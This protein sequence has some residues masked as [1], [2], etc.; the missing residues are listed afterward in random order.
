MCRHLRVIALIAISTS[1]SPLTVSWAQPAAGLTAPTQNPT[2]RLVEDPRTQRLLRVTARLDVRGRILAPVGTDRVVPLPLTA[3]ANLG[4]E[5]R[6]LRPAGEFHGSLRAARYLL[7]AVSSVRVDRQTTENNLRMTR[8][9]IS[10]QGTPSGIRHVALDGPLSGSE[11]ELLDLPADPLALL[12]AMPP[13][14]VPHDHSWKP[15][16][17]TLPL[18]TGLDAVTRGTLQGQVVQVAT[19][20]ATI[21]L[22]GTAEGAAGGAKSKVS[23]DAT[24]EFDH[25]QGFL[26]TAKVRLE[27]RRQAGPVSPG[28]DIVA[29]VTINRT[30]ATSSPRLTFKT[31]SRSEP[32]PTASDLS[33]E[34]AAPAGHRLLHDRQWHLFHQAPGTTILRRLE[35]GT[36]VSQCNL[37]EAP[38]LAPGRITPRETFLADVKRALGPRLRDIQSITSLSPERGGRG[39]RAVATGIDHGLPM[40]WIY[41]LKATPAGKQIS[42]VF[43]IESSRLKSWGQ[44][45]IEMVTRLS[46]SSPRPK[47]ARR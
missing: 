38:T 43:S 28:L 30:L 5:E 12:G 34:L 11:L 2:V 1:L 39:W 35:H 9:Y 20:S 13:G 18:I 29:T 16:T 4:W 42:L 25:K 6:R 37:S 17:W 45:D 27:E 46:S 3:T 24:I 40:T 26:T 8:R 10:S 44:R 23:F 21:R 41:Y 33:I 22:T 7:A 31:A 32:Q 15:G 19:T 14:Q 47:T 36:L